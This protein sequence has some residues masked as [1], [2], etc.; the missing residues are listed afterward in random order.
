AGEEQYS[1]QRVT[2][3]AVV[4]L[5]DK[6]TATVDDAMAEDAVHVEIAM[7]DGTVYAQHIEH[8]IGSL[9][10]PMSDADLEN[11]FAKLC[12]SHFPAARI[13]NLISACWALDTMDDAA[14]L[15]RSCT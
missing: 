9:S 8:A 15:P 11:K 12:A 5:R 4:A 6:V 2:D 1:D 14:V 10:R 3:H 7:N 13:A